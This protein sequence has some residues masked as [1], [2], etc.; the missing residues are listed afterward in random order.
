MSLLIIIAIFTTFGVALLAGAYPF[1]KKIHNAHDFDFPIGESLAVGVF[2]GAGLMHM[3]AD[4]ARDFYQQGFHFPLAFFL[5]GVVFL[6]LL[7]LEHIEREIQHHQGES[8]KRFAVIAVLMLS[9]H[10]FLAGAALGLTEHVS[11]AFVMLLAILAH[12]WAAS[13]SLAVQINK[14]DLST[15]TGVWLFLLFAIMTPMGVLFG[16]TITYTLM[17]MPL[18]APIFTALAAGTFLYFGSLHGLKQSV[19]VEK[20]CNLKHFI[21]V[22]L[23]F[24]LMA[25]IALTL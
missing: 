22:N 12:K 16:Q 23:G 14:S 9:L 24:L 11:I 2:L 20:C 15:K 6:V 3:L 17:H 19:L 7:L 5:A 1:L 13:F 4:A 21:F 18:L 8:S 10:S 25:V